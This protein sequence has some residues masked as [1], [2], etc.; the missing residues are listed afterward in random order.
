M[1]NIAVMIPSDQLHIEL[2]R[3]LIRKGWKW[4]GKETLFHIRCYGENHCIIPQ[5][6]NKKLYYGSS[7]LRGPDIK[8]VEIG[9][10]VNIILP[11]FETENGSNY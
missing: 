6:Y 4:A 11:K 7:K 5:F 10:F 3:Y 9:E 8:I 2:Q 1:N